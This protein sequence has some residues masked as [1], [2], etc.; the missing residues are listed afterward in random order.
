MPERWPQPGAREELGQHVQHCCLG[1]E[2]AAS[3]SIQ[4][5]S[6]L[7]TQHSRAGGAHQPSPQQGAPAITTSLEAGVWWGVVQAASKCQA[8]CQGISVHSVRGRR[9]RED[10]KEISKE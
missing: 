10:L 6:N 9:K 2:P 8:D 7:Q 4:L 3:G 1:A 5:S